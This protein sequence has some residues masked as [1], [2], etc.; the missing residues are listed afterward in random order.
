MVWVIPIARATL[1]QRGSCGVGMRRTVGLLPGHPC[2]EFPGCPLNPGNST[3]G[4]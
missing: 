4:R 3:R 2:L 1:D